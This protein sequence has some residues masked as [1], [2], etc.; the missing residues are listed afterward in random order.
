[1]RKRKKKRKKAGENSAALDSAVTERYTIL[2]QNYL[3]R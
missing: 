1:M 3:G 2:L